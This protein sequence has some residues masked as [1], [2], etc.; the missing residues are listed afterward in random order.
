MKRNITQKL[1]FVIALFL[2]L[3][4]I[5]QAQKSTSD[6]EQLRIDEKDQKA[7]AD[8]FRDVDRKDYRLEFK[9]AQNR[10]STYGTKSVSMSDLNRIKNNT[11]F[12]E[13]LG[14]IVFVVQGED[15]IYVLAVGG[16]DDL[17]SILGKQKTERLQAIM[18]KYN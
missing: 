5:T 8:L 9:T 12:K 16:K 3:S 14:W 10:S 11:N 6:G 13:A 2:S 18:A 15:V 4:V 17:K 7:I 1:I